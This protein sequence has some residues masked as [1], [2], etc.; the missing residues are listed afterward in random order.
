VS[1]EDD[2][3]TRGDH[4]YECEQNMR[5]NMNIIKIL[6]PPAAAEIAITIK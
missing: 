1:Q 4:G 5:D 2:V 3:F 6:P